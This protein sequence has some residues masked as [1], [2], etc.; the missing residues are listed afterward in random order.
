MK[1]V[2][3]SFC[4]HWH[5]TC[6]YRANSEPLSAHRIEGTRNSKI[7]LQER[8]QGMKS[9]G[10]CEDVLLRPSL[11]AAASVDSWQLRCS[12]PAI[13]AA[14][15]QCW[16]VVCK[17]GAGAGGHPASRHHCCARTRR[18]TDTTVTTRAGQ[19]RHYGFSRIRLS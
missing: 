7:F 17:C 19:H 6:K 12:G 3:F 14:A 1:V 16:S 10:H 13:E 15:R 4:W 18:V 8:T 11:D 5:M 9:G 2:Q